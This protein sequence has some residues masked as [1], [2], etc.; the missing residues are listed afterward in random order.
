MPSTDSESDSVRPF[1]RNRNRRTNDRDRY[2]E[3]K[4]EREKLEKKMESQN[5]KK[6][7]KDGI[8]RWPP[9]TAPKSL[10]SK[11]F[12]TGEPPK[13]DWMSYPGSEVLYTGTFIVKK[14]KIP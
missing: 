9:S 13:S 4:K 10:Q 2:E 8:L 6:R 5:E 7:R 14:D 12:N 11:W 3:E 1:L